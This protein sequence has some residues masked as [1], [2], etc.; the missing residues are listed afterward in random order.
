MT[1]LW[2]VLDKILVTLVITLYVLILLT[3]CNATSASVQY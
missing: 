2:I 1:C 3:C